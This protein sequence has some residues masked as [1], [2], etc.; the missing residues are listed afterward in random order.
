MDFKKPYSKKR[1][2]IN[3][4][5]EYNAYSPQSRVCSNECK[6]AVRKRAYTKHNKKRSEENRITHKDCVY[7]NK[8][9]ELKSVAQKYC[10]EKCKWDAGVMVNPLPEERKCKCCEKSFAPVVSNQVYCSEKCQYKVWDDLRIEK[11]KNSPHRKKKCIGCGK[12]FIITGGNNRYCSSKCHKETHNKRQNSKYHENKVLKGD[13]S[14]ERGCV[15]CGLLFTAKNHN[16]IFCSDECKNKN[17]YRRRKEAGKIQYD[18][19]YY[20]KYLKDRR[21]NDPVFYIT[22]RV[23]HLTRGAFQRRGYKKK[24]KTSEIIGCDWE[25]LK[26]HIENQFSDGM[27]WEN[28]GEW[29]I[30]HIY[31]LS[32]CDTQEEVLIYSHFTNLQPMWRDENQDKG[33]KFIG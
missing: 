30:D 8:R 32:W 15:E 22:G 3:C 21:N 5:K 16:S 10:S 25:T 4:E 33:A 17:Q 27:S 11:L 26:I 9:F 7:C 12:S 1:I 31:P 24:G 2:C 14:E 28:R 19:E 18:S 13:F 29:D 20:S 6:K 23:R